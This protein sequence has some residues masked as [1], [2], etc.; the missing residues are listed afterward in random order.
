VRF[1]LLSCAKDL[2]RR[3][4][5]PLALIIW[6]GIPFLIG[7]LMSL[8]AGG[9]P[10]SGLRAKLLLVDLD[11]SFLSQFLAGMDGAEDAP[12]DIETVELE[13]GQKRIHAGDASALLIL[14]EGFT[15]AVL[16]ETPTTLQLVT[17]PAQRILPNII[18]EAL[19]ILV[20]AG[21][22]VQRVVGGP[23]RE[24]ADGPSDQ[25]DFFDSATIA[26]LSV[27]FN[28]R[29]R[30]L[31][32]LL[33]PPVLVLEEEVPP[34]IESEEDEPESG[35]GYFMLPA[36][37][38]M[39]LLFIA[40]GMSEDIWKEKQ[41]GTLRRVLSSPRSTAAFLFGKLLAGAT[42]VAAVTLSGLLFGWIVFDLNVSYLPLALLWC[43]FTGGTML[44]VFV[45]IQTL[46]S[47]P[48]AGSV[49]ST[50]VLFPLMM[51]GGSFFPF[52]M[53]PRWMASV[54]EWTPNG[55]ALV[56]F[57]D[58]LRGEV[59]PLAMAQTALALGVLATLTFALTVRR[60]RGRF[61][62]S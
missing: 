7:G 17:N 6:I 45:L 28:D 51:L 1:I 55:M 49:V 40:Q 21:F 8:A 62:I 38:M 12:L 5:D 16:R 46:A 14:P 44:S 19:E 50:M 23:L 41:Q 32:G 34:E 24:L 18:Q 37:L 43:G 52:E 13:E 9:G 56:R 58:L 2:R 35:M 48:R 33:F 59:F 47:T 36:M 42:I 60:L 10:G 3:L 4:A 39:A 11:E 25:G 27:E 30:S 31:D 54:G 53:M 26:R 29:A 22:Y 15:E 61:L 20:E 57:K